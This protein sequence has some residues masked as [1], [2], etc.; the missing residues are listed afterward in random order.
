MFQGLGEAERRM[1]LII[2]PGVPLTVTDARRA[3]PGFDYRVHR[4][5]MHSLARKGFVQVLPGLVLQS[6]H[7]RRP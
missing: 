1:L 6:E 2:R 3:Y 7:M 4:Q 5:A